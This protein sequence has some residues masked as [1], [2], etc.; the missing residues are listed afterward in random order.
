MRFL[1]RLRRAPTQSAPL[2]PVLRPWDW[3]MD[4]RCLSESLMRYRP[5]KEIPRV[6]IGRPRGDGFDMLRHGALEQLGMTWEEL[7]DFAARNL[8]QTPTAW[9]VVH[10][11]EG[12]GR[13]VML[14]LPDEGA[15]TAS[16]IFDGPLL[17]EAQERIGGK[18]LFVGVPTLHQ[19]FVCDGSPM[20]D[21][22]LHAAFLVW[23]KQQWAA[24][25][26]VDPL[27]RKAFVVRDG[28]VMGV[29]TPPAQEGGED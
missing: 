5:G 13:P 3:E 19:L 23:L 9:E 10:T 15:L 26:D 4:T 6:A 27:S 17:R 24:S 25:A 22:A 12:T 20:A 8:Q 21:R 14:G 28:Q 1:D 18:M 11:D 2:V 29:Y 16:R 7:L